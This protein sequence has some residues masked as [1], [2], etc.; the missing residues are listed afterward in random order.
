MSRSLDELISQSGM[1]G[2]DREVF[3]DDLDRRLRLD[4]HDLSTDER[5]EIITTCFGKTV[6]SV[7][8]QVPDLEEVFEFKHCVRKYSRVKQR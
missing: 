6:N 5:L 1:A 3:L 7:I 8:M 2:K 4:N